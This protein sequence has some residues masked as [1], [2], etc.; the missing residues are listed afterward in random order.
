MRK[1]GEI[2]TINI[3]EKYCDSCDK[4]LKEMDIPFNISHTFGYESKMDCEKIELELCED[5]MERILG[6]QLIKKG[7][8]NTIEN[9]INCKESI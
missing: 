2:K 3:I 1:Y 5:C 6:K 9:R 4:K 7:L 8:K